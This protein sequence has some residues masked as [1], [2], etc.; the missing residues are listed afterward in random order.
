MMST[1]QPAL[2]RVNIFSGRRNPEWHL[3]DTRT[4]LR[5]WEMAEPV[6]EP[7]KTLSRL[8]YSGCTVILGDKRW[9]IYQGIV[10]LYEGNAVS[11]KKDKDHAMEELMLEQAPEEIRMLIRERED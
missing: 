10:S 11:S 3:K 5:L 2:V 9:E 7:V 1:D 8:G 4:F 6:K